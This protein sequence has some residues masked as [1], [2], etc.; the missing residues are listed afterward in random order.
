VKLVLATCQ[1]PT[2]GDPHRNAGHVVRQMR[3]ARARGAD[4]AHFPEGALSGYAPHDLPS[5]DG[6]DWDALRQ[7]A[8]RVLE[9]AGD[10]RLWVV[11][12]AAHPLTGTHK[13]HNS[14]YVVDDRGRIVDRYD[15]RFC[16]SAADGTGS[17]LAHYT[18]GDH[19][20]VFEIAGVRCGVLICH[21]YR[22]P[23]LY[24]EHER[25]GVRLVFHSFHAANVGAAEYRRMQA[26]V[27]RPHHRASRG[28]TLP[29]IT[30][31]A[32]VGSAAADNHLWISCANSSAPQSCWGAFVVRPD[33]VTVGRLPRNRGGALITEVE[34]D[35]SYYDATA[36]WRRRAMAG[37]LHSGTLVRDRR[38]RDRSSL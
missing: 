26:Y 3:A 17:E 8:D 31:H 22:Y 7:A 33:G 21:E 37:R 35:R 38:S 2:T 32:G 36:A 27:G 30:M 20:T 14:V 23:E 24:R 1:F 10:L 25:S 16:A 12:G 6:Y 13:P 19:P 9:A 5:Y 29:E 34:L 11:L 4:V 15:K 18:P 28:T